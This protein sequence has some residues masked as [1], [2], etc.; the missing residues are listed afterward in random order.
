MALKVDYESLT[1]ELKGEVVEGLKGLVDGAEADLREF[2]L[3]IAADLVRAVGAKDEALLAELQHQ[4]PVLA[5]INR[6]RLVN[7]TWEQVYAV[8][9]II[10][11]VALKTL[12]TVAIG[13]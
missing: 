5:E 3:A 4:L 2:G 8:L 10:G 13:A 1:L 7:A 9:S 11:R 6:I 12:A